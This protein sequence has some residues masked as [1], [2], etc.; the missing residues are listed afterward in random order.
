MRPENCP[1][2]KVDIS[3]VIP[4]YG[5]AEAVEELYLRLCRSLGKITERF[6]IIM[7]DDACPQNSWI[8]IENV[9]YKDGRVKGI[10]LSRN[11]GQMRAI[12]AGLECSRG[13]YVVVMDCDLQDPPEAIPVLYEKLQEG[14]DVVFA[15]RENRKDA[16]LTKLLS[17][18]FYRAYSYFTDGNFDHTV[19]NFSIS[20]R[21]VIR[22]YCRMRESNRA[23][24]MFLRWLG[25]R[26]I[27]IPVQ[28]EER[29]SGVSSY[30]FRKKAKLALEIITS[31]SNKPL[32]FS[33]GIGFLLSFLSL[34][35]ILYLVIRMLWL[36]DAPAGWTTIVASIYLMGGLLLCSV[37]IVGI[38]IGN[39]F[40]ESK[41]RPLYVI[42]QM[43]N[44]KERGA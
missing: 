24:S 30:N 37:G 14:Y 10:Q 31:Q 20:R 27:R 23:F 34:C 33:I 1:E 39:I 5:C 26:T 35:Y 9:C 3:V 41:H 18:Y 28:A 8:K 38:Y 12:L 4:V 6:E 2:E 16:F 17:Q 13:D 7:V 25:F 22:A 11:F 21:K 40:T 32:Y 15:G 42:R 44:E 43:L 29:F 36:G 19:G